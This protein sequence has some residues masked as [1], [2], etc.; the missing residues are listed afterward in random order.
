MCHNS[1]MGGH[2]NVI[3]RGLHEDYLPTSEAQNG[4]HGNAGR[5]ATLPLTL[6]FMASYVKNENVYKLQNTEM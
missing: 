2:I 4:F 1:I 6:H 3:L 5:L